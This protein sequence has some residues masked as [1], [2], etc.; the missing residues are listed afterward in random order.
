MVVHSPATALDTA[1]AFAA[2]A[3]TATVRQPSTAQEPS[4]TQVTRP[5][6]AT[7]PDGRVAGSTA[8]RQGR[9]LPHQVEVQSRVAPATTA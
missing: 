7:A 3:S 1:P 4:T 9:P 6:P 2:A 5:S 8:P